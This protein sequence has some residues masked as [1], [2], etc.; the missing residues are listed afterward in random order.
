[1]AIV[2]SAI[3]TILFLL[4]V[5]AVVRHG[6]YAQ[7][8]GWRSTAVPTAGWSSIG[9]DPGGP[10]DGRLQA[11]DELVAWNGDR[12]IT[13]VGDGPFG[14]NLRRD[15]DYTLTIR[16]AGV[17]QTV[18]LSAPPRPIDDRRRLTISTC[19]SRWCGF[20]SPR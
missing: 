2:V 7:D 12:S 11:G 19:S 8:F 18:T 3:A 5:A 1:M 20:S 9:C 15:A 4:C 14:R 17:E 16:R 13:R 10:A 6:G